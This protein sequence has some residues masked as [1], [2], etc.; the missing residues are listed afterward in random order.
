[1]LVRFRPYDA[2]VSLS[3]RLEFGSRP[4]VDNWFLVSWCFECD[5]RQVML[6]VNWFSGLWF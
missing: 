1:M 6:V 2:E 4:L 5:D 3:F